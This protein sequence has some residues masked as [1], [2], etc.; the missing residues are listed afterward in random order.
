MAQ[1]EIKWQA[2]EFEYRPKDV[3]WYWISIIISAALIGIAV[4]QKN[5]LFGFLVVVAEILT[6]VWANRE[7]RTIEF[8][9]NE[10]GVN[11][12]GYKFL[13]WSEMESFG[14]DDYA[15]TERPAVYFQF[16]ARLKTPLKITLPKDRADDIQKTLRTVLPQTKHE[17]SLLETFEEFIGF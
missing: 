13:G 7:P 11:I 1:F 12:G 4:W 14:V 3:S 10:K 17:R 8:I 6:L 9:L 16:H 5:F 15:E 2:S